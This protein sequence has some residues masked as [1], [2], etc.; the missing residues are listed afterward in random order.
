[1]RIFHRRACAATICA[2]APL[3]LPATAG[4]GPSGGAQAPDR[5]TV[6]ELVCISTPK[7]RCPESGALVKGGKVVVKGSD[8]QAT[9]TIV[10]QGGRSRAD[11]V[12]V[13]PGRSTERRVEASVPARARSGRVVL[14]SSLGRRASAPGPVSL[15]APPEPEPIDAAPGASFFFAGKRQPAFGFEVSRPLEARVELVRAQ[16]GLVVRTW[17]VQ[18][19]PG[20]RIEVR[21]DGTGPGGSQ[22]SGRY[23]FR[24]AGETSSAAALEPDSADGF[25]FYDH[26][27]PI[28]GRHDLGQSATNGFGGGRGHKGQDM[29][30]A[31]GTRLAAARGGKV[32]VAGFHSAAGNYV[33]IDGNGT[34]DDYVYMHMKEPALVRTGDRVFTGQAIGEVGETG[35]ASGCHLHFEMWSGPGWYAG[36]R[37]FDP[38]PSL[39]AWDEYS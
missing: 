27:F 17:E 15:E 25:G 29:F 8:L 20:R 26:V 22:P 6:D 32:Q 13:R 37:A 18:A 7:V 28:R 16:D 9:S 38:L 11:D 19:E 4:A 30:A 3:G 39:R 5:P 23:K 24:L 36:G 1:M 33:V 12:R 35:R 2:I 31:C 14:E 34:E 21:W 10:F